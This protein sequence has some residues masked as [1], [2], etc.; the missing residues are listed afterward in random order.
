M[1]LSGPHIRIEVGDFTR[2]G[3]KQ[4]YEVKRIFVAPG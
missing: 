2:H 3:R 1:L 4:Y